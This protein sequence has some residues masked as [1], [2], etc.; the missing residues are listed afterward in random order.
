MNKITTYFKE[1]YQE[2]M[3]KVTWPTWL[4]LQ[5]S[6]VIVL[7]ATVIITALVW[8]MDFSSNQLLK[9]VYSLFK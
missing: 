1:S 2:L 5:Q 4:Q 6:T 7:V 9:L 3:E 8:V